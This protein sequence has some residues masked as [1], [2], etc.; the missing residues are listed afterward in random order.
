MFH[1][2][3]YLNCDQ[4]ISFAVMIYQNKSQ[5]VG[6]TDQT[7][8]HVFRRRLLSSILRTDLVQEIIAKCRQIREWHVDSFIAFKFYELNVVNAVFVSVTFI[9]FCRIW[10]LFTLQ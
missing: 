7:W 8:G 3:N 5:I 4:K 1:V 2:C 10:I 9:E 6:K